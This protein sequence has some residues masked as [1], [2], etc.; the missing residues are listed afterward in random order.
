MIDFADK[1]LA[2]CDGYHEMSAMRRV[3]PLTCI[4]VAA[5]ISTDPALAQFIPPG[6]SKFNPPLPQPRHRPRSRSRWYRRWTLRRARAISRRRVPPSVIGSRTV[7]K[8]PPRP[9]SA[10]PIAR[11]IRVPAPTAGEARYRV[12][13]EC[14]G[15]DKNAIANATSQPT[16]TRATTAP[17]VILSFSFVE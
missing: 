14:Q 8:R 16:M 13:V 5:L 10:R 11:P 17:A 1:R 6:G 7:W 9:D 3:T 4:A 12:A 15:T 2:V